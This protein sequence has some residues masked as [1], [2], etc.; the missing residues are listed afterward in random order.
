MHPDDDSE[1]PIGDNRDEQQ[2]RIWA[3]GI[4]MLVRRLVG[5][6]NHNHKFDPFDQTPWPHPCAY[7]K[8]LL[9]RLP[10]RKARHIIANYCH[11]LAGFRYDRIVQ[12]A[13]YVYLLRIYYPARLD[14][15]HW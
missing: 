5:L 13:N 1:L 12:E 8:D 14:N 15:V 2:M 10:T 11:N 9:T 3:T 4:K 6:C 7:L